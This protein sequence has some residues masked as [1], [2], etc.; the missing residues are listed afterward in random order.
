MHSSWQSFQK[1]GQTMRD[2]HLHLADSAFSDA[3]DA[4]LAQLKNEGWRSLVVN[5]T[6]EK[7]W[8]EVE[9]LYAIEPELVIPSYGLHPWFV[10]DRSDQWMERL[11]GL[12]ADEP[13]AC[14]GECGLDRWIEGH[15]L[16]DQRS[17]LEPQIELATRLNRPLTLHCLRAWGP[18]LEVLR[19]SELPQRGF[20][21]HACS[22]SRETAHR[23]LDLGAR[24]SYSTYFTHDRK[25]SVREL[26]AKLPLDRLLV[27]TDAPSMA[28]PAELSRSPLSYSSA[29]VD[30]INHP[31]NLSVAIDSL[32]E[33]RDEPKEEVLAQ[34][35]RNFLDFFG[36]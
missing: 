35:E 30:S 10:K 9:Q 33:I 4:L 31:L 13:I 8:A 11:E 2:A 28:P 25:A 32:V 17:V 16:D 34:L 15:D 19:R 22:A 26:Y 24:F 5:G 1:V 18:L 29:S 23:L 6:S 21:V 27:E 12:I 7:D 14:V 20:L 3:P 36:V